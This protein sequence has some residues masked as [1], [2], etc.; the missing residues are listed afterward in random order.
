MYV[1]SLA[2]THTPFPF[3]L[4]FRFI[5]ASALPLPLPQDL[6]SFQ[7]QLDQ[8]DPAATAF[9]TVLPSPG[10]PAAAGSSLSSSSSS[11]SLSS[12]AAAAAT[13]KGSSSSSPAVAPANPKLPFLDE[14]GG[15]AAPASA[16]GGVSKVHP[17]YR[18]AT[19]LD[20][21]GHANF[22]DMR[23]N[24]VLFSGACAFSFPI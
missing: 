15:G 4:L 7:V 24:G 16:A 20:T 22:F 10:G 13:T 9:T 8:M 11:S 2:L 23:E 18:R 5:L 1:S 21:P 14:P 6:Y 17:I 19:F 3:Q 12:S